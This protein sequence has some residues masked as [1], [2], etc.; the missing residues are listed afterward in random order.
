MK[1]FLI[2]IGIIILLILGESFII[3]PIIR[4]ICKAEYD[5]SFSCKQT[6]IFTYYPTHLIKRLICEAQGGDYTY[7]SSIF[8][9]GRYWCSPDIGRMMIT[10]PEELYNKN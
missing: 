9:S 7:F 8:V 2:S 10:V 6:E 3:N 4:N 5:I 1:I